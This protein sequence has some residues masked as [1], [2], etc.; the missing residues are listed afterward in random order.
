ME[1]VDLSLV[2]HRRTKLAPYLGVEL[3]QDGL[4][5]SDEPGQICLGQLRRMV[6]EEAPRRFGRV[7]DELPSLLLQVVQHQRDGRV[8]RVLCDPALQD[9][10]VSD[11]GG[12][13]EELLAPLA[14]ASDGPLL[15]RA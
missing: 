15:P 4:H 8:P 6:L 2:L 7:S 9:V 3:L 10:Q 11:P 1:L 13:P 14:T 5:P 12:E